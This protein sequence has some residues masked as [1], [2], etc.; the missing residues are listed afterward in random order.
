M[1]SWEYHSKTTKH[2]CNKPTRACS[3]NEIKDVARQRWLVVCI[4]LAAVYQDHLHLTHE[5]F[6]DEEGWKAPYAAAIERKDSRNVLQLLWVWYQN[7]RKER[8]RLHSLPSSAI[9]P[10]TCEYRLYCEDVVVERSETKKGKRE[11]KEKD[12]GRSIWNSDSATTILNCQ[13]IFDC[14]L[15]NALIAWFGYMFLL[16]ALSV[17]LFRLN[18]DINS[19]GSDIKSR[20]VEPSKYEV[21]ST[22]EAA[23]QVK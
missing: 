4:H 17:P 3:A 12:E 1:K 19:P 10:Q 14:C 5:F 7:T 15:R 21:L 11:V 2:Y 20:F 6:D 22:F 16:V 13:R 9:G 18:L 8:G 23:F